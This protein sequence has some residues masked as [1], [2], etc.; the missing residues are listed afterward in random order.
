MVQ[1]E[2]GGLR[3]EPALAAGLTSS[4]SSSTTT[5]TATTTTTTTTTSASSSSTTTTTNNNNNENDNHTN[6]SN[7][8]DYYNNTNTCTGRN[9][10]YYSQFHHTYDNTYT[11]SNSYRSRTCAGRGPAIRARR[12]QG[13]RGF[14]VWLPS[15]AMKDKYKCKDKII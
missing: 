11:I 9:T 15:Q 10:I 3:G 12:I 7:D 1:G 13:A 14:N 5:T 6:D 8:S 2:L 4:S